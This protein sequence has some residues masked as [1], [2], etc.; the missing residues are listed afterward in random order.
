MKTQLDVSCD[1]TV[2]SKL[3]IGEQLLKKL[4][5]S[6]DIVA[7]WEDPAGGNIKLWESQKVVLR[8]MYKYDKEGKRIKSELIFVSGMRGGKTTVAALISLYELAKLQFLENPQEKY[9]LAANSEI[10]CI[11]VAPS[12]EQALDTVFARSKEIMANSPYF[13][14]LNPDLTFNKA[15]F[16]KHITLKAL[17]SNIKSNV[18]RTIKCFV[19]DEVSSF[20]DA[21][22]HSPEEIYFK[23]CNSTGTFKQ[24]NENVR[25]AISSIAAPGDFITSLYKQADKEK[26][27]WAEIRWKKTWELNPEMSYE[28][29]EEERKR[30]PDR[31]AMDYG[32]EEGVSVKSFF[33]GFKLD[34]IKKE[35]F[36]TNVFEGEP[37]TDKLHRKYGFQPSVDVN[38]LNMKRY[39]DAVTWFVGTDP[40]IRKDAFGL[41][42]GYVD[43]YGNINIIGSTVFIAAKGEEI[44]GDDIKK[45]LEPVFQALPISVY[46]FDIYFH[47]ELQQLARNYN[48]NVIQHTLKLNDWIFLRN[49]LSEFT[50]KVPM[51]DLLF[52]EYS[53]LQL[54]NNRKVDHPTNGS[55]DQADSTAQIVSYI[56]TEEEENR[57]MSK[58]IMTHQVMY[59]R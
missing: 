19:A 23:L 17:G 31:F 54:I 5:W 49:D 41:S 18:G 3:S 46:I 4:L 26:W 8:S 48:I 13:S 35:A 55:K 21:E 51:V 14:S 53:E 15:K 7:F 38:M 37:P 50:C 12:Q 42:V 39:P 56:R 28:V 43:L 36:K 52:K 40:A 30:N 47:S 29:L 1:P 57:N 2:W 6:T 58:A 33:N 32:A 45:V 34:Q 20:E 10:M 44:K 9:K 25:V 59:F 16:P 27:P 24:W 11:N 22:K